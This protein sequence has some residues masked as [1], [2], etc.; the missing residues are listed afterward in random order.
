MGSWLLD[1]LGK[2]LKG[3]AVASIAQQSGEHV[4]GDTAVPVSW[5]APLDLNDLYAAGIK[6]P[7]ATR[8]LPPLNAAM[9]EFDIVTPVRAAMFLAQVAWESDDFKN[10]VE[11]WGPTPAQLR[12]EGCK[13]LGNTQPGDG[14]KWRGH[15]L[16]QITGYFNHL[17]EANYFGIPI[18]QI[19]AWLQEPVGACRSAAHYFFVH[20]CNEL[21]DSH[22]L[23]AVTRKING[24]TNGLAGRQK[25]YDAV[26]QRMGL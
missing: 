1:F 13:Y 18:D 24:G 25:I 6:D 9:H 16:I 17:A 15:G 11:I 21:A 4:D 20:H 2:T 23:V 5:A 14:R 7:I 19:A 3:Q 10:L 26:C 12:Y 8:F 22:D